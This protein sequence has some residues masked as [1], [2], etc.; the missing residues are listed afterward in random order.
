M[1]QGVLCSWTSQNSFSTNAGL[2]WLEL[3]G[4]MQDLQMHRASWNPWTTLKLWGRAHAHSCHGA[5]SIPT[6]PKGI[7]HPVCRIRATA[8]KA[9][10]EQW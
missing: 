1:V 4:G 10:E 6:D 5:Q 2:L 9:N 8:D 3:R 7:I